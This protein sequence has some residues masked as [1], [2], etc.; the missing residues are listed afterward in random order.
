[1]DHIL[2]ESD[3]AKATRRGRSSRETP[4]HGAAL[5]AA[6]ERALP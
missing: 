4:I 3:S 5:G 6:C 1:M 2:I